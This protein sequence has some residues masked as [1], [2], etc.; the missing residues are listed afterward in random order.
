[1]EF[2]KNWTPYIYITRPKNLLIV[3]FTQYII[4][5]YLFYSVNNDLA[6]SD[7]LLYLF[8]FDTILIAAS[9]YIINDIF[10][11]QTDVVNK[12]EKTYIPIAI[13][14]KNAYIYYY[15]ILS[16]GF[17]IALYIAITTDNIP[18]LVLYPVVCGMLYLY[19]K[20][21][22]NTVLTGNIIVSLFVSFVPGVILIAERELVFMNSTP[23]FHNVAV[24]LFIFYIVFSFIVNLIR[25]IIKDIEDENGDRINGYLTLP[26]KYGIPIAKMC[27]ISLSLVTITSLVAWMSLTTIPLDF[28]VKMYILLL[29]ATPMMII[30]QILTGTTHKR[31]FS[32]VSTILKWI[33]LAGLGAL[34]LIT[35][36]IP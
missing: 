20:K 34:I 12:P 16:T 2:L 8:I 6:L 30:V 24:Q 5:H 31:D 26:I 36:T 17:F 25:E 21:F 7:H 28:R 13:T 35:K 29:I 9:G 11:F 32:K 3:G 1:M 18:L 33:M 4:Y 15:L 27:C 10:D 22:K 23:E 19:S 14:L